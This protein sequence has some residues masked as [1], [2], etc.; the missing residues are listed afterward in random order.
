MLRVEWQRP[1]EVKADPYGIKQAPNSDQK[2]AVRASTE[3]SMGRTPTWII[4]PSTR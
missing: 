1:P 4:H 2:R 3:P